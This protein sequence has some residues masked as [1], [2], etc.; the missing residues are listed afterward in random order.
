MQQHTITDITRTIY[1]L[2]CV[3]GIH[4]DY[5]LGEEIP[6]FG[7]PEGEPLTYGFGY[8]SGRRLKAMGMPYFKT[9]KGTPYK[10]WHNMMRRAYGPKKAAAYEDCRVCKKWWDYQEFA[11]WYSL[12]PYAFEP[13]AELDKDIL[14]QMNCVYSPEHCSVVP[15]VINQIFRDTRGRRGS[16][17]I[18]VIVA[19]GGVGFA[20]V[21]SMLGKRVELGKFDD[22]TEAFKAYQSAHRAYCNRLA[23]SYESRLD[24]RV[25]K[26]LRTCSRHIRD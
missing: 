13:D 10:A 7:R 21:M 1:V 5:S 9:D 12:Q 25:I 3:A 17:P 24:A 16:L 18:G 20:S 26:R 14:D 22:I 2:P 15:K 4:L 23:D 19:P 8:N 11:A 6:L